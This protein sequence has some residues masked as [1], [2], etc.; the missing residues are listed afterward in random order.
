MGRA[1]AE[2]ARPLRAAVVG[3][4]EWVD[5]ARVDR[6]PEP[7]EILH[8][9]CATRTPRAILVLG[10]RLVPHGDDPLP[11][12]E[13]AH[14]GAV[15]FTG[16]DANA[17]RHARAAAT[18]VAAARAREVLDAGVRLDALVASAR[19]PAEVLAP[20]AL[21][22]PPVLALLTAGGD[23]GAWTHADGRT[24]AW[25]A[26]PVPAVPRDAYGCGDCFAAGAGALTRRGGYG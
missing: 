25:V 9:T 11:W 18:L 17:L 14:A 1:R 6:L 13:L 24:G 10:E 19:D 22:P 16:G 23:G 3:H 5:F 7:G 12:G 21:V 26:S 20:D 4:V 2:P 8:A 15:Y